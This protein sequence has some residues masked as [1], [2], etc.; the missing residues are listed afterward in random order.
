MGSK[1]NHTMMAPMIIIA[2][3]EQL[4]ADQMII[5]AVQGINLQE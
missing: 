4:V 2:L 5:M 1:E 3:Q